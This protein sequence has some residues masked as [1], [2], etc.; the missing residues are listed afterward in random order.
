M[1]VEWV[2]GEID[3]DGSGSLDI[4]ELAIWLRGKGG[5]VGGFEDVDVERFLGFV[6][7]DGSG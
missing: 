6:D 4:F 7:S 2:M 3:G 5:G 1:T